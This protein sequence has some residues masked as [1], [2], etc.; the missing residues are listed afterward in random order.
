DGDWD[1]A[2]MWN[3]KMVPDSAGDEVRIDGVWD[4]YAPT[5]V[6]LN[7]MPSATIGKLYMMEADI[8]NSGSP[9]II[10]SPDPEAVII[11][12]NDGAPAQIH[13]LTQGNTPAQIQPGIC[14]EGELHLSSEESQ[15]AGF[16]NSGLYLRGELKTES[17]SAL[18]TAGTVNFHAP[19]GVTRT[20]DFPISTEGNGCFTKRGG[21][22]LILTG[23]PRQRALAIA[24]D[25]G[26]YEN[27]AVA[28]G[29]ALILSG[30]EITNPINAN[31]T[32]F[33]AAGNSLVITNGAM[34]TYTANFYNTGY[35]KF[36]GGGNTLL[37]TG[38]DSELRLSRF[39]FN[40]GANLLCAEN[41]GTIRL[42]ALDDWGVNMNLNC[43]SYDDNL[44]GYGN[45]VRIGGGANPTGTSRLD[46]SGR[47]VAVNGEG[48]ELIVAENGLIENG[49]I[50]VIDN[51][52]RYQVITTGNRLTL[53]GGATDC[54]SITIGAGNALS[55]VFGRGEIL[56]ATATV[57]IT[58]E[59]GA[60]IAPVMPEKWTGRYAIMQAPEINGV[61][62]NPEIIDPPPEHKLSW[63][64][65]RT[66]QNGVTTVWLNCSEPATLL[67]IK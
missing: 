46:L 9:I 59:P 65:I 33:G 32:I 25:Y 2:Q 40:G 60:K 20:I 28:D 61:F 38:A 35:L 15:Y 4:Y 41:G 58:L 63:Q 67:I 26:S 27:P 11:M 19:E 62:E 47:A 31:T 52:T 12:D 34:M 49:D 56:P 48:C 3:I 29:G 53:A 54:A 7:E 10:T 16:L 36:G 50:L 51:E 17:G 22:D 37:V 24:G 6:S 13:A 18:I 55:P 42:Y 5:I 66:T 21:G 14:W 23:E 39:V 8:Y 30:V 57:R 45:T 64:L 44:A 1:D 43:N